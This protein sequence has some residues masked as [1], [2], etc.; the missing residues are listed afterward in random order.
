MESV[1]DRIKEVRKR[2]GISHEA[3]AFNLGISQVAY[4]KLEKNETKLTIDRLY[5]IAEVLEIKVNELLED[6]TNVSQNIYNNKDFTAIAHQQVEN[7]Y[8]NQMG[9]YESLVQSKEEQI[10]LL[11][12][13]LEMYE[14][15][16]YHQ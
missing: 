1:I 16:K 13:M 2:K 7:L 5:K 12:K 4:T 15:S 9:V 8:Q 11:K 10:E 3:M 14:N 6:S